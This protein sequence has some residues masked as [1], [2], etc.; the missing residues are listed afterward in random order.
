LTA[1][2]HFNRNIGNFII[3]RYIPSFLI[4]IMSFA[5]FWIPTSSS[6]ARVTLIVTALLALI[7]QQI[8][9]E[10][11]ISYI[12]ALEVWTILCIS[13]VF[14]VLIEY[15]LAIAYDRM[16]VRKNSTVID[17]LHSKFIGI[18]IGPNNSI[19]DMVSRYFFPTVFVAAVIAYFI[20]Y[21]YYVT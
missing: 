17:K 6:P 21:I 4:V 18:K 7:A 13:F 5:G 15:A 20:I 9:N 1:N 11:N 19:V 2:I 16:S 10:L 12:Y 14:A 3:K 8:Q